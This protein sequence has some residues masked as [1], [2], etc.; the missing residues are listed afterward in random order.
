MP[1]ISNLPN[2]RRH[3]ISRGLSS[4]LAVRGHKACAI[5]TKRQPLRHLDALQREHERQRAADQGLLSAEARG[6]ILSLA[7][8]FRR[9]WNDPRTTPIER[10]RIVALLI[11]DVTLV[12]AERISIHIRFG[13][14]MTCLTIAKP[15]PIGLGPQ[16]RSQGGFVRSTNFSRPAPTDRS[17]RGSTSGVIE[18]GKGRALRSRKSPSSA[19]PMACRAGSNAC[20]DAAC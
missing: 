15:K 16:N 13:G 6:R 7:K 10:K 4:K 11:E 19:M 14:K 8:E 3:C 17:L 1:R 9:V 2:F 20:A 18:T 5:A 12:K